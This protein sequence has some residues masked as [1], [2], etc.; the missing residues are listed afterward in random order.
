MLWW[1]KRWTKTTRKASFTVRWK[2]KFKR[3]NYDI[4]NVFGFYS[5]ILCFILGMTGLIIFFQPMM[6]LTMKSLG[7][8]AVDWHRDLPKADKTK[9]FIDAFP[10]MDQ[11]FKVQPQKK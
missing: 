6:N 8:T 3:F 4:H 10:L 7:A 2:A 5:L 11:L 1:P 9:H